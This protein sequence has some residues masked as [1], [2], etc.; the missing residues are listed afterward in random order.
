MSSE[1]KKTVRSSREHQ[2]GISLVE[3]LAAVFIVGLMSSLVVITL[4]RSAPPERQFATSLQ[5]VIRDSMDRSII[6]GAPVSIDVRNNIIQV[7]DW[8]NS[9]WTASGAPRVTIEG[10]IVTQQIEPYDPYRNEADPELICDPT[11][12]VSPAIFSVTGKRERWNVIVTAAG[13]VQLEER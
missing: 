6:R 2:A 4:P 12:L 3:V 8:K 7:Q 13:E 5:N 10:K 11:G 9:A 1:R